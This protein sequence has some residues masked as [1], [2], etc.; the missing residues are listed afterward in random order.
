MKTRARGLAVGPSA[1]IAGAA[2][3][4][5][6]DRSGKGKKGDGL[7]KRSVAAVP[8][9]I[10]KFG[11]ALP[12]PRKDHRSPLRRMARAA[13]GLPKLVERAGM[14]AGVAAAGVRLY[15]QV[16]GADGS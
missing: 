16:A 5:S 1:L 10:E 8:R 14:M 13:K 9:G 3:A 7:L 11:E 4:V 15:R 12:I 2:G 6:G